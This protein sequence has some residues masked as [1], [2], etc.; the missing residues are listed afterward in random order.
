M[1]EKSNRELAV[2]VAKAYIEATKIQVRSNNSD[3]QVVSL[4][5]TCDIIKAVYTT[6]ENLDK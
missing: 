5:N 3:T 6:L 2:D 4:K 1:S